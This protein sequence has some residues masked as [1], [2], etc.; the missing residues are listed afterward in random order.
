MEFNSEGRQQTTTRIDC[1]GTGTTLGILSIEKKGDKISNVSPYQN[2]KSSNA[3]RYCTRTKPSIHHTQVRAQHA[4]LM[5]KKTSL[6]GEKV[7]RQ[8]FYDSR[9]S[10]NICYRSVATCLRWNDVT[11]SRVELKWRWRNFCEW[12][13]W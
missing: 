10:T 3:S 4:N 8:I 11:K 2:G 6:E 5:M 13:L 9:Y 12:R 7:F 1:T